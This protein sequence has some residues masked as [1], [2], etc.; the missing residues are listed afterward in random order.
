MNLGL[1]NKIAIVAA[2]SQGLGRASARQLALE[3]ATVVICSRREK[4][5]TR[6]AREI[7]EE[8]GAVVLP[9]KAD[10]TE[11]KD[12]KNLVS[13]A[14]KRFGTVHILVN[15]AGGP[16]AGD[17]LTLTDEDWLKGHELTLM[18]MV[19]LTR[20]VLPM[21]IRQQWGRIITINSIV[22][23]Q[24]INELLLSSAV[25]PGIGGLTKV[26]ANQY[27]KYN[28]TV[29][30]VCP[31]HIRT[32]RQEELAQARAAARQISVEQYFTET[33]AAI[34]AARLGRPEEIGN[35]VA[36][37]ASEQAA[38]INGVNLLVDG[39]AAKGVH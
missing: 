31:G 13:E 29:N 28:I 5:I 20:A 32:Q 1:Q 27:A 15:N 30:T 12:I 26:L 21:M 3:G 4:E 22:A 23:K 35:A 9:V 19:R 14:K 34:P 17:M 18:S 2:A 36:F 7:Q 10:V 6:A 16:P 39:S 8:T 11:P 25:R 24:P 38:Y 33:A 37:L